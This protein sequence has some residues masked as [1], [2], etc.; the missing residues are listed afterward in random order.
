MDYEEAAQLRYQEMCRIV[1][2]VVFAMIAEGLETRRVAI[3]DVIRTEISKGIDKW[4]LDQIQ[5]ME[6]AVK[7]LEE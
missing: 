1:G 4:D 5:V 3:A 2:D 7:L 6:L